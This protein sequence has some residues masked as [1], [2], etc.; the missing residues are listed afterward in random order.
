MAISA[1]G[2]YVAFSSYANDLTPN[3]TN[4]R[5]DVFVR[6]RLLGVTERVSVDSSEAE[7]DGYSSWPSL[8]SDGR[9]VAFVFEDSTYFPIYV[10]DRKLGVTQ[11]VDVSSSG[12]AG[13]G[14]SYDPSIS[15]DGRFV[16]FSS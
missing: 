7:L 6:D 2:R 13:N 5:S 14:G 10:R 15:A 11:K 8:S 3:D 9:F 16:A 1:D 12:V 4:T